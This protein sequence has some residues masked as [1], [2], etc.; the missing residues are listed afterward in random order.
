MTRSILGYFIVDSLGNGYSIDEKAY[1]YPTWTGK[2]ACRFPTYE[3]ARSCIRRTIRR[4]VNE[5]LEFYNEKVTTEERK[6][7]QKGM[8]Q[9][10]KIMRLV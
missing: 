8:E 5:E 6:Q 7:M 2:K 3:A 9:G 4:E 10:L 1:L